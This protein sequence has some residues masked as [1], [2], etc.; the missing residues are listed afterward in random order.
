MKYKRI[1]LFIPSIFIFA[2]IPNLLSGCSRP[3][4]TSSIK[5]LLNEQSIKTGQIEDTPQQAFSYY[6]NIDHE[7]FIEFSCFSFFLIKG[8][9]IFPTSG[10]LNANDNLLSL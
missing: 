1:I 5:S 6:A 10:Q 4:F 8:V 2:V 7:K 3:D 9:S